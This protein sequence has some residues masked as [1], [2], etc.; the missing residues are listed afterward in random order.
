MLRAQ[1]PRNLRVRSSIQLASTRVPT[2]AFLIAAGLIFVGGIMVVGGA[3]LM[4]TLRAIAAL[5][6][7][8]LLVFEL[9]CWGRSTREV[10]RIVAR[11]YRRPT[12]LRLHRSLVVLPLETPTV[13]AARRPRWH[14]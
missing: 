3:D 11:H 7:I 13:A 9:R 6:V 5:I 1:V 2:R 4:P 14:A 8:A 12:R 10:A